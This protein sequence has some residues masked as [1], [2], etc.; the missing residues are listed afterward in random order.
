MGELLR[1]PLHVWRG[2]MRELAYVPVGRHAADVKAPVLVL[3]G[4]KDP[5]FP[6][7]HHSS[8]LKAFPQ[9]KAHVFPALGHN[10][11]WERPQEVAAR[12]SGFLDST[13]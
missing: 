4:G 2:V 11:N 5:L 3:S 8:L 13:H 7:E 6:T 9:A 1:I 12:L 10:P